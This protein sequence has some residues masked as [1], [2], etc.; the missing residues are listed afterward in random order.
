MSGF[1]RVLKGFSTPGLA[2]G[3]GIG[4]INLYNFKRSPIYRSDGENNL[5]IGT[6]IFIKSGI[7]STFWPFATFGVISDVYKSKDRFDRHFVPFSIY[8]KDR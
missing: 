1:I 8:G 4:A 2:M 3:I 6:G 7:Y 5:K